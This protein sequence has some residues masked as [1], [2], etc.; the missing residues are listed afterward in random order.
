M[1]NQVKKEKSRGAYALVGTTAGFIRQFISLVCGLILPR[2]ILSAFGSTYNG[3][4]SSITQFLSVITLMRAGIG[5]ASRAALYKP[6]AEKDSSSVSMIMNQ[7]QKYMQMS[8][9]PSSCGV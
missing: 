3:L 4:T 9:C 2:L 7:M 6:L 5:G 8:F 1:D